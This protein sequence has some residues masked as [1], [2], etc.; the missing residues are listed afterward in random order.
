MLRKVRQAIR[1]A[2]P[3]AEEVISYRMPAYKQDGILVYF[4]AFNNH[5]SLFPASKKVFDD[6]KTALAGF[7]T[8]KGT[9][10]FTTDDPLPIPLIKKMVKARVAENKERTALKKAIKRTTQKK[11]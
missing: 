5:C 6:H 3:G 7:K 8:S 4:A 11:K 9:I 1:S 10:Q 2:A